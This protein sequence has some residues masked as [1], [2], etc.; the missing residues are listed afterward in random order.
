VRFL[1]DTDTCVFW[2]RGLE[3]VRN[4]LSVV[5]PGE[6]GVSVITV[7]ELRYGAACSARPETN[8]QAIDDFLDGIPVLGVDL[9]STR[10][11]GDVKA[12]LRKQGMLL[13]DFDLAI[14]A[15][16]LAHSLTLVTGNLE[17]FGRIPHLSLENWGQP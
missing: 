8:H 1:L 16:A 2:L 9:E 12:G 10:V 17:H 4:R 6:T 14:A 3:G 7:A 5:G 11:F 13:D 15:T